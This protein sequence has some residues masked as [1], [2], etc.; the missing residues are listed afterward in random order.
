MRMNTQIRCYLLNTVNRHTYG[1]IQKS[2]TN[3]YFGH[4][5]STIGNRSIRF[6]IRFRF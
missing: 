2:V 6:G 3:A 4:V 5:T 1:C